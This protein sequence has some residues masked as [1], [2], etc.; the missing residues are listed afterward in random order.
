M[1]ILED[2]AYGAVELY[3]VIH[4]GAPVIQPTLIDINE[5]DKITGTPV[6]IINWHLIVFST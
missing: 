5:E 6:S 3:C 4:K 1:V 2:A